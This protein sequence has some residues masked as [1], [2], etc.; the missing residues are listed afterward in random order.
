MSRRKILT[1][2]VLFASMA[3]FMAL[4]ASTA[5]GKHWYLLALGMFAAMTLVFVLSYR[6]VRHRYETRTPEQLDAR[7]PERKPWWAAIFAGS[8]L[9]IYNAGG[10]IFVV[11]VFLIPLFLSFAFAIML[12]YYQRIAV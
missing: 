12:L 3:L 6:W 7:M 9:M 1:S 2:L 10:P 11:V 4:Y 5:A 8:G